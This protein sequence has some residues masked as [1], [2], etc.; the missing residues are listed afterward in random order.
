MKNGLLIDRILHVICICLGIHVHI[1][2]TP[3]QIQDDRR[4]WIKKEEKVFSDLLSRLGA[5]VHRVVHFGNVPPNL[6]L[7]FDVLTAFTQDSTSECTLK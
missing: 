1:H 7:H 3:Y 5:P 4:P 2:V 6:F